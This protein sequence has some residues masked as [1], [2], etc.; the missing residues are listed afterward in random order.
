MTQKVEGFS[1]DFVESFWARVAQLGECWVWRRAKVH[2]YGQLRVP[3]PG[4]KRDYAHRVGYLLQ[5]GPIPDGMTVDHLCHNR[6]AFCPGGDACWH[7][8]C[9]R[10][11]HLEP[12]P[13]AVNVERRPKDAHL[14]GPKPECRYGHPLTPGNIYTPPSGS[15]QCRQCRRDAWARH[16]ARRR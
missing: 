2:G 6:D 16:D 1:E 9:V 14:R 15:P 4:R 5:V 12:V 7:R 11:D 3:G 8:A 13:L 10:G